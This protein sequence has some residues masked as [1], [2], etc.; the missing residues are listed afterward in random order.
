VKR[1][2]TPHS[3]LLSI[4]L[5]VAL[6]AAWPHRSGAADILVVNNA[7]G[8]NG[9]LRQAI[10]FNESL[11][12]GNTIVFSNTVTGTITLTN[13]L[14]ELLISKDVTIIG[15]GAKVLAI[16]GNNT[17]RVFHLTSSANVNISGLKIV[18]GYLTT[19][20]NGGAGIK[21][22][23][24]ILTLSDSALSGNQATDGPAGGMQL[25]GTVLATRC[26]FSGNYSYRAG[27]GVEASG[28]FVAVNCTFAGN[29]GGGIWQ[30]S[31]G[32]LFLTNC[33]VSANFTTDEIFQGAAGV[34]MTGGAA[35]VR[36]SIIANNIGSGTIPPDCKGTFTSAGFNLIGA[37]NGSTGWGALGDQLGTTN[38]LLN[39][40]LGPLQENGGTTPTMAPQ[41][42]SP[43][44]D[45]GNS[46]GSVTDQRGRARSYPNAF[47]SSFP[48]GGDRSDIGAYEISPATLV[49]SNLNDSGLGS[50]RQT[51]QSAAPMDGDSITFAS[52]VVGAI[53]LTSGE[54]AV[55]N[56]MNILGLGAKVLAVSGNNTSRVFHVSGA[57]VLLADLT[58][59]KGTNNSNIS[60][61][62]G[63]IFNEATGGLTVSNCLVTENSAFNFGA[64][65]AN[66]GAL[67][68]LSSAIV[69]N[70][71]YGA[72]LGSG[73]KGG[74]I[75]NNYYTWIENSTLSGNIASG[76]VG[77]AGGG[78]YNAGYQAFVY[79][80][81]VASNTAGAQ[82]GGL[83]NVGGGSV[84]D[85][86][87]SIVANNTG[88]LSPD[89]NGPFPYGS[90]SLIGQADG[91]TGLTNGVN[92]NQVGSSA[93]PLDAK[94][95]PLRDNGGPTP[96]H[97]LLPGSPAIDHAISIY[98]TYTDQRGAPRSFIDIP[99]ATNGPSSD[100]SDV[101]AFELGSPILNIQRLTSN[102]VLSW[103]FYYGDFTLQSVTN[104]T[105]SNSWVN[106]AGTPSVV[107]NQY[108]L[109]NGPISGNSFFRLKG[110]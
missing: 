94:L 53:V 25:L 1:E 91:S 96:T 51:I 5:L 12:G 55:S 54:L 6:S 62:G 93:V 35:T 101:G 47:V 64:G 98:S 37:I 89:V 19:I 100:L 90:F 50:L 2:K 20:N 13:V 70:V 80:S 110:N 9:T 32:T 73:A 11:G 33:T 61:Y 34:N 60:P 38:S 39:P 107:A 31:G 108:V 87:D 45:Q 65:I 43:V 102:A 74:G 48:L 68:V 30:P 49:V 14:G 79:Y 88:G 76:G 46:S 106:V 99:S 4:C 75:Y 72:G 82:G 63:G 3:T 42:G 83:Y 36:N 85:V 95:G 24:G 22:E 86:E 52:N 105:A 58:I 57:H 59:T 78:L 92:W 69:S 40:L 10:Q 56:S 77:S 41:V 15:P 67:T 17:H 27:G 18:E 23:S 66:L 103:P 97:A 104:V 44:V 8:G 71:T 29:S 26:T 7:D 109:T 28:T 81:T 21:Q 84:I 16:S